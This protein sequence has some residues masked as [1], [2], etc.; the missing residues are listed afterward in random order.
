MKNPR[1]AVTARLTEVNARVV[2]DYNDHN[3]S[4]IR[5]KPMNR[6]DAVDLLR[7]DFAENEIAIREGTLTQRWVRKD[8]LDEWMR[9][10][11]AGASGYPKITSVRG[12]D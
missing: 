7:D 4:L 9:S 8:R 12:D 6:A 1:N 10:V 5:S 11:A 2:V 3:G